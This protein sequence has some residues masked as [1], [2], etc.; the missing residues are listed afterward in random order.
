MTRLCYHSSFQ[1]Y[2][3]VGGTEGTEY[4]RL[5]A[6]S[7]LAPETRP[8]TRE[9]I[10]YLIRRREK[11]DVAKQ[12]PRGYSLSSFLRVE[13]A[14]IGFPTTSPRPKA[15][16]KHAH[17]RIQLTNNL[18]IVFNNYLATSPRLSS[19]HSPPRLFFPRPIKSPFLLRW[20]SSLPL[21]LSPAPSGSSRRVHLESFAWYSSEDAHTKLFLSFS[22][23]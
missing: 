4:E 6:S 13:S 21:P 1:R 11:S 2:G 5:Q 20:S 19:S 12:S 10:D 3:S 14:V 17:P 22:C 16:C 9:E 7:A 23:H 18:D 15:S 8:E